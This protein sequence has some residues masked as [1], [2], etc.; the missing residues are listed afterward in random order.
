VG[1]KNEAGEK[2]IFVDSNIWCYYF[3][4]R[5]PEHQSVREPIRQILMSSQEIVCNTIVVMEIA[6]YLVR[7]FREQ[8]ARS[9]IEHFIHLSNMRILD[10]DAK[11]MS[12]SLGILLNYNYTH[13]LGGRDS[14]IIASLN[15]HKIKT[16]MTHDDVFKRLSDETHCNIIDPV[17][18]N[19]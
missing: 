17:E 18:R 2:L 9:K 3:D 5:L 16:L 14:T 1:A 6:H 19:P 10:F 11:A 15:L 12:E 4:K 7:H 13:G 8:D